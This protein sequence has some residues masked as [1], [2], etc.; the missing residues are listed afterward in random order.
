MKDFMRAI[1]FEKLMGLLKEVIVYIGWVIYQTRKT[2]HLGDEN[3]SCSGVCN[4]MKQSRVFDTS[5]QSKLKLRRTNTTCH[6]RQIK[7]EVFHHFPRTANVL[8][9]HVTKFLPS[10]LRF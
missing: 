5:S 6:K 7:I 8:R 9:S 3:M 2:K 4:M 1:D 10:G